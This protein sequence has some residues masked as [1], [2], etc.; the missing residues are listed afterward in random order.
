MWQFPFPPVPCFQCIQQPFWF[1][2]KISFAQWISCHACAQSFI[3]L[4]FR[5]LFSSGDSF[6]CICVYP[7]TCGWGLFLRQEV[8]WAISVGCLRQRFL[9]T[10]WR[11]SPLHQISPLYRSP[12][13]QSPQRRCVRSICCCYCWFSRP[14]TLLP[15]PQWYSQQYWV[16][17]HM[18]A[19]HSWSSGRCDYEAP[20][21]ALSTISKMHFYR[22]RSLA[23]QCE[24]SSCKLYQKQFRAYCFSPSSLPIA[25]QTHLR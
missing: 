5:F 21:F 16:V 17:L 6:C 4:L 10:V 19:Y 18:P 14:Q 9:S 24:T 25:T 23:W 7:V 1:Q 11:C 12:T 8:G 2:F 22:F 13:L 3:Y 15:F 20:H